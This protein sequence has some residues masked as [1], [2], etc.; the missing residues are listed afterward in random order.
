MK[1]FSL[2]VPVAADKPAYEHEMPYVFG[3]NKVGIMHCVNS[4]L[5]LN[6]RDFSNIYFTILLCHEEKYKLKELFQLQFTRLNLDKASVTILSEKTNSQAETVFMTIMQ[7]KII[8]SIYIK[9]ADGFFSGEVKPI[10]SISIY[11]LEELQ[12][13][14]PQNKSYVAVD[15]MFYI[16]NVIEKRVISH[17]FN[18]GGSC[19]EDVDD[20]V[21]YYKKIAK[22]ASN[23]YISHII[24]SMLLDKFIFRPLIVSEFQDFGNDKLFN[25][26]INSH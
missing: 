6:L 25:F 8:G 24:Y 5:G 10:N 9:D 1:P 19:F 13:V 12:F 21:C 18:A 14:N 23:I 16:T 17:Y 7:E 11:P 20:Y 22:Y 3:L 26:Y 4:I 2:I 15:D